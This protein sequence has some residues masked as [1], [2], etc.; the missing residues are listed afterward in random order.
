MIVVLAII[1]SLLG[2]MHIK[3]P[4]SLVCTTAIFFFFIKYFIIGETD[5]AEITKPDIEKK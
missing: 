1:A 5:Y 3:L 4:S 2:T